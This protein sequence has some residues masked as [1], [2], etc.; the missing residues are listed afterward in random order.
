MAP[1]LLGEACRTLSRG[2]ATVIDVDQVM[3]WLD[4]ATVYDRPGPQPLPTAMIHCFGQALKRNSTRCG[5]A[6][7]NWTQKG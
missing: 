2:G 6:S 5:E 4:S 3:R 1:F 7:W